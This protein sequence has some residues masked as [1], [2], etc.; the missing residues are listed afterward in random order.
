MQNFAA[1]SGSSLFAKIH[2]GKSSVHK[3]LKCY[4]KFAV[5]SIFQIW[6]RLKSFLLVV[7]FVIC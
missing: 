1:S 2:I 7:T 5:V 4:L 3:L 6:H